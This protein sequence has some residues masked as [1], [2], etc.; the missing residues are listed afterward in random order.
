MGNCKK[1]NTN[2]QITQFLLTR[3]FI[4]ICKE[5]K[6][7]LNVLSHRFTDVWNVYREYLNSLMD[8]I[9]KNELEDFG[10]LLFI[11]DS[12]ITFEKFYNDLLHSVVKLILLMLKVNC[13]Q[14]FVNLDRNLKM[15]KAFFEGKD[16]Y[17]REV[18]TVR[19]MDQEGFSSLVS[20]INNFNEYNFQ[21]QK[22]TSAK[23]FLKRC[24]PVT[25]IQRRR[26][27]KGHAKDLELRS[28]NMQSTFMSS[29][30]KE[31]GLMTQQPSHQKILNAHL[32]S[33]TD[34]CLN[35]DNGQD[36]IDVHKEIEKYVFNVSTF[37]I[38]ENVV[39]PGLVTN[40]IDLARNL[41]HSLVNANKVA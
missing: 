28:E 15:I 24:E 13:F 26:G 16:T 22:K 33:I 10:C 23:S 21:T 17:H 8:F 32:Q 19:K 6:H 5:N 18:L 11:D 34:M 2:L 14:D 3:Y 25:K 30:Q 35:I 41:V 39:N 36:S 27:R 7:E 40:F 4:G 20:K 37:L 9:E 38:N 29:L 31:L 12:Y 1:I